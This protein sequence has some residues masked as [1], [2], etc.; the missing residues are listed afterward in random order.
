MYLF[1]DITPAGD[2][3]LVD[4]NRS[5]DDIS[6]FLWNNSLFLVLLAINLN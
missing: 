5:I 4:L 3:I 1:S 2:G 6:L